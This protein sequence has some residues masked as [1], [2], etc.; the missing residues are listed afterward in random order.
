MHELFEDQAER[1]PHEPAVLF[2]DEMLTYSELNREANRLARTLRT[3]GVGADRPAAIMVHRSA[4]MVIGILAIL[5][6]GGAYVPVDPEYPE[7]RIRYLLEDCGASVLVTERELEA[8]AAFGGTVVLLDEEAAYSGDSANLEP[9]CDDSHLAYI[10]Y[11]SGTTGKPKGVMIEHRQLAAAAAAWNEAYRLREEG[12]RVLQWASFSFDV[13][14]GD[15]VRALLHGGRLILCPAG[16]RMD[17]AGIYELMARHRATFFES[18]PA[19][20]LPF[21][22]YV[23]DRG[24]DLGFLKLLVLGSD[25]CPPEAFATLQQRWGRQMRILNSY[26]VTE[27]CIDSSFYEGTEAEPAARRT[28]PIG[29]PLPGVRMYIVDEHLAL[30]PAGIPGELYIGGHGVGRGYWNRE[31]LTAERFGADPF[32]PEGRMYRTGDLARWLPD[33]NIE[34][35]GRM[36]QQVKIRGFRIETGEVEAAI[37]QFPGVKE[38][39][40][41]AREDG[42]GQKV[43]CAYVVPREG[44]LDLDALKQ[45]LAGKLPAHMVP[46]RWVLL[47]RLPLTPNGKVDRRALPS[48]QESTA[49]V[50]AG[51]VPPRT[52]GERAIASVWQSVL[53]GAAVGMHDSFF[54][55]G[56][57]SI[58]AIQAAS[59]LL[60]EGYRLDLKDLFRYP[61]P[62]EL[63]PHLKAAGR[64]SDQGE[65]SGEVPLTP[66]LHW[67][68]EQEL[69]EPHHYNQAVMLCRRDRFE[70]E[71]LR[72]TAETIAAH[73]DALRLVW[74]KEEGGTQVRNRAVGDGEACRMEVLDLRDLPPIKVAGE[75]SARANAIQRGFRLNEGPLM[76]LCLFQCP[77]GDHLLIVIHHLAVDGVSWRILFEDL[78][79]GYAQASS[80][81]DVRLPLKTASFREWAQAL[82]GEA[83]SGAWETERAYWEA[84]EK[85]DIAPL[86]RDGVCPRPLTGDSGTVTLQLAEADTQRLLKEVHRAYHT[87]ANDILLTALGLAVREWS[88][89]RRIKVNLEGHGREELAAGTD[90]S[91][92]VG[93]FTCQFPVLLELPDGLPLGKQIKHVKET[94][95]RV[96]RKGR[97]YGVLR[98]LSAHGGH[99][100]GAAEPEISFNYLGQFDQDLAGSGF[101]LSPYG[102]GE[103]VSPLAKRPY[104]LDING[105]LKQGR[106]EFEISYCR[107]EYR[108]ETVEGLAALLRSFLE[109]VITHCASRDHSE[110]TPSDVLVQGFSAEELDAF[111]EDV[112]GIGELENLYPLTPMQQ[113]MLFHHLMGDRPEAY[114]EQT[115]VDLKGPLETGALAQSLRL[116]VERHAVL[117]TN[118]LQR[119]DGLPLQAVFR[120]REPELRLVDL[121]MHRGDADR[122]QALLDTSASEDRAR[123][124]N[125]ASD[126][127]MRLTVLRTGEEDYRFLWSFHHVLMDGWCLSLMVEEVFTIYA[128]LAAGKQPELPAAP[129]YSRYIE[130]LGQ[131]E[132]QE[133][134]AYW[135]AYL[136]GYS[137]PTLLPGTLTDGAEEPRAER[138]SCALGRELTGRLSREASKRRTTL[139]SWIQAAWG[140]LLQ[141]YSGSKDVVFGCVVSGRP[142]ELAGADRMLGLF[143]NTVPVRV[144]ADP[145]SPFS[146]VAKRLQEDA[147]AAREHETYPLYE[148]QSRSGQGREL[149]NHIL[150]FENYPAEELLAAPGGLLGSGLKVTGVHAAEQTNYDLNVIVIPGDNLQLHFEYNSRRYP[151]E[152]VERIRGHLL[153]LL[154]QTALRPDGP[155]AELDPLTE[156]E[157]EQILQTF[158]DTS[159]DYPHEASI[160]TLFEEQAA[161]VPDRAAVEF[162]GQ[163]LSYRELNE[164]ADALALLLQ[165]RG[166]KEESPVAILAERSP[167]TVIGLLAILK[168]GGAYVPVDPAFPEERIRYM[169]GDSGA[170]L[171][172]VPDGA[173]S[174][175]PDFG[176]ECLPMDEAAARLDH[177]ERLEPSAGPRSLAYI[178]YTSGTTGQPKGVM[179]EHRSVVRLVRNTDYIDFRP[180]DR[181][182]QTGALGFDA[183]T[184]E[185]WGALLS[186]LS[187]HLVEEHILLDAFLLEET[188]RREGITVMWLTSPLFNQLVQ[189]NPAL[190]TGL[191]TLIVGG[192]ALSPV[193]IRKLKDAHPGLQVVN[194]YGPTE[195]TTFSTTYEIGEH[196]GNSIPIGRPIR[197]SRAYIVDEACRLL[198]I[199]VPGELCVAGDGLSRGYLGRPELTA[200]KFTAD[201]LFPG[202]RMYR[203][204][205]LARWLPDGTIE[206]LGRLDHQVKI[207]GYRIELGEIENRLLLFGGIREA[208]VTAYED[209]AGQKQLCAYV[210]ADRPL[211]ARELKAAL[212]ESLPGYMVPAAFVQLERMPLTRNGK[213]DRRALPEPQAFAP[214]EDRDFAAPETPLEAQLAAIWQ[215]VLGVGRVGRHDDFFELGGHSLRA[216]ALAARIHQ[217]LKRRIPLKELFRFRTVKEQAKQLERLGRAEYS[218]IPRAAER[219]EYP[220]SSAQQRMYLLSLRE[221][222]ELSYNM[223]GALTVSGPLDPER[224]E[225]AFREIVGRHDTLRTSFHTVNG[226]TV[227]RIHAEADFRLEL[228]REESG[229]PDALHPD[230]LEAYMNRFVRPFDLA[231][232]PLMR[233]GCLRRSGESHLLLFDMH[234]IVSDG[235]SMG[236]LVEEFAALYAGRTLPLLATQY[237]DYTMWRQA[238]LESPS[239]KEK[240]AYWLETFQGSLPVLELPADYPRGAVRRFEG[241]TVRFT[242][243]AEE[244]RGLREIAA[245]TGSTLY[246]V[247]LAVYTTL[248]SRYSGAEDL[249]VGTPAAGRHHPDLDP[250]IGMFVD[251]LA[252]RCYPESGIS[253]LAYLQDVR[254][255]SLQAFEHGDYP[256]DLLVE[257]LGAGADSSRH[258]LFDTMFALQNT[259]QRALEADGIRLTPHEPVT[260]AVKFDLTLN[261]VE[262]EEVIDCTLEFACALFKRETAERMA[263]HLLRLVRAVGAAPE[264]KLAELPVLTPEEELLLHG[265][266]ADGADNPLWRITLHEAFEAQVERTPDAAAV[267]FGS[268]RWTYRELNARANRLARTLRQAGLGAGMPAALLTDRSVEMVVGIL[269]ILKAGGA[270]VPID[271]D[272]PEARIR[273]MLEDSGVRMLVLQRAL[274]GR[275]AYDGPRICV[276]DPSFEDGDGTNLAPVSGPDDPA[277]IIYSSGTT[278]RPKG[279][280]TAHRS[281]LRVV[282]ETNYI[283]LDDSDRILQLSNYAFDGSVFDLW[284]ALTS[285]GRLV[286]MAKEDLLDLRLLAETLERERITV[287]FMTTSLFNALVDTDVHALSGTRKVLFGGERASVRHVRKALEHLG[288]GRLIN[289]YGPT[290]TT[291]FATSHEVNRLDESAAGVPIGR[292]LSGTTAYVLSREGALQPVGVP[293]ELCIG[294]AGLAL[295]YLGQEDLTAQKFTPNP[296][297]PAGRLYRTG[298]LVRRLPDGTLE[299]IGRI[300]QQVKI[301]GHRIELGEIEAQLLQLEGIDEAVVLA[302]S[303]EG[304][305]E[306][307]AYYTSGR[308]IAPSEIRQA[309]SGELPGYM[310]PSFFVLLE[311]MPLTRNG[312]IDRDALPAPGEDSRGT[313]VY[314]APQTRTEIRL[315]ELWAEVLGGGR[316][317]RKDS[318]FEVGGHS[319]RAAALA[320]HIYRDLQTNVPLGDLFRHPTLKSMA[321]LIDAGAREEY[322]PIPRAPER[323]YYPVS[324]EQKRIYILS[325]LVGGELSYNMPGV[326]SVEGSLDLRRFEEA[327]RHLIARHEALR[328]GFEMIQGEPV[329]RVHSEVQWAVELLPPLSGKQEAREEI[330]ERIRAFVRP[331]RL[332]EAP[333]LRVGLL[334]TAPGRY[335]MLYDMH[336]I[337]SD[338]ISMGILTREFAALYAGV[339][340]TPL[341][342][343]YK[344][345][346]VWQREGLGR[347]ALEAQEAYWLGVFEGELPLLQL[348]TD[349]PRGGKPDFSAGTVDFV[350]DAS[351]LQ[352]L[353]SLAAASGSTMFML[354][355]SIYHVL[356]AKYSGQ[357][358]L[359]V[360]TPAA[361]RPHPD[362]APLLGMFVGTLALRSRPA[363]SKSFLDFLGEVRESTLQALEHQAY[364]FEELVEKLGI[365]R[366]PGRHPLF[367]TLFALQNMD[368]GD[369]DGTGLQLHPYPSAAPAAKFDLTLNAAEDDRA[370]TCSLEYR[371]ALF[372][373]KTIERMA[374]HYLQ[375]IDAVLEAPESTIAELEMITSAEKQ[376][377]LETFNDTDADIAEGTI[378]GLIEAQAART[379]EA[380]ALLCGKQRFTYRELN[381]RANRLARTLL[382]HDSAQGRIMAVL[383]DRSADAVIAILAV[384]KAGGA[385]VPVDPEYPEERIRY[386]LEDSG[387]DVLL[388]PRGMETGVPF[389]GT[390]IAL[391]EEA[392]YHADGTNLETEVTS[393]DLA[394][395]IYTSGT[396]GRPKGVMVEHRGIL[397]FKLAYDGV[398]GVRAEDKVVQFASMSFDASLSEIT[399]ALFCGAALYLPSAEEVKDYRLLRDYI[400][401]H[402]ITVATLPPAYAA[403][404]AP[405]EVPSLRILITAG[406]AAT[407]ELIRRW[408]GR[409]D[410]FNAYGPT[411]DSICTTIWSA[412]REASDER[413]VRIGRPIANHRVYILSGSGQLQPPGIPGELCIAGTGLARGYL[414]RPELTAEKFADHP[415]EP[416]ARLY[417]TGDLARWLPD[418]TLEHLGRIDHQV[419]I[420]GYRIELGEVES[421]L[422]E[423]PGVRE[424]VV[425]AREDRDGQSELCAYYTADGELTPA[426]VRD[427]LLKLLPGY[428]VPARFHRL[429]RMPLTPNGKI[430]RSRL[431]VPQDGGPSLRTDAAAP[432][433]ALEASLV[434]IWQDVIGVKPVGITDSF[435]E[436]GGHSLKGAHLAARI[437]EELGIGV[438]LRE[439]FEHP[440]VEGLAQVLLRSGRTAAEPIPAAEVRSHYPLSSSQKRLY[441][442]S[443]LEG[444]ELSYNMPGVLLLEGTLDPVRLEEAL[445][446]LIRRHEVLRTSFHLLQGVPM[447]RVWA[448]APFALERLEA[449]FAGTG[450]QDELI[451]VVM[452]GFLR[453]FDLEQ[454]PLLRAGLLGLGEQRHLLLLDM[455]HLVSDGASMRMLTDEFTRLY[456]GE[457]PEPVKLQYKD[458][459]VWQQEGAGRQRAEAQEAY[460]LNC[461][462]GELPVLELPTDRPRTAR[463]SFEGGA[464][465]FRIGPER[466][467][468]LKE[469]AAHSE[470][471]LYMALLALYNT[472]LAKYTGAEDLIVGTPAE[473][474]GHPG[475]AAV[476][477]LFV[478]TLALRTYPAG[479]KPFSAYLKEVRENA[480][481]AFEHQDYGFDSLVEKLDIPRDPSRHPLFDTMFALQQGREGGLS[482]GELTLNSLEAEPAAA[483]F[484][485]SL[486]AEDRGEQIV[487]TFDYAAALFHKETVERFASH[488][489]QLIDSVLEAPYTPIASLRMV[490]ESESMEL[491]KDF[492]HLEPGAAHTAGDT[493]HGLFEA[494]AAR[495]PDAAA[496]VSG[497]V[498]L[499]YRELNQRANGVACALQALG[500]GTGAVVALMAE[501][502]ADLIAGILGI[503][504]S[505]A[506]YVPVGTELPPER[507]RYML[508]DAGAEAVVIQQSLK[509]R[510]PPALHTVLLDGAAA[511]APAAAGPD[512]AGGSRD[513]AYLLYTSGTTG[514][515]KG[516]QIEHRSILNTITWFHDTYEPYLSPS[517][518][519]T[520]E[521]TF[522][523]SLEQIFGTLL[524]GARLHI[525]RKETML[526]GPVFRDYIRRHGIKLLNTTPMLMGELLADVE[527]VEPLQALICGG[528]RLEEGLKDAL[529]AK[530]YELYNHY[531]PTE[532]SV[533]VLVSRCLPGERVTLGRPVRGMAVCILNEHRQLQ[534][535][536]AAGE[537]Y[538]AGAGLARGYLNQPE[539]TA[540]KFTEHPD[541]PGMRLYRTGDRARRLPDGRI[542]FLGRTD[543]QVKIRGYRIEP[544]EIEHAL[545]RIPGVRMTV[546][547]VR[548]DGNGQKQL[549]AYYTAER[550]LPAKEVRVGLSRALPGYMVPAACMQLDRIP[551]TANG[552]V[553][554]RALPEA[555]LSVRSGEPYLA[556]RSETEAKLASLWQEV[557]GLSQPPGVKDHFFELGGHSLRAMTLSARL[558]KTMHR[559]L[560][561]RDMF[562]RPVLEEMADAL[563]R[564]EAGD[565]L[566]LQPAAEREW[567]PVSSAQKR[568]YLLNEFTGESIGYNMPVILI[569]EG[570]LDPDRLQ[571]AFRALIRRQESLRTQ[572][573]MVNGE[574]VQRICAE[575]DYRVQPLFLEAASDSGAVDRMIRVF[576]RPFYLGTAPLIR[577]G[578][579]QMTGSRHLLLFDTHHIVSDGISMSVLIQE[580]AAL[581]A[582]QTLPPLPLQ[583]KDYAVWQQEALTGERMRGQEAYWLD[584][585][586]GE[587][588]VLSL[589][590]DYARGARPS[591][592]GGLVEFKLDAEAGRRLRQLAEDA[593]AT[594]YMV[595]LAA[596]SILL[597]KYGGDE[598][599]VIGTPTAGRPHADLE[600]LIGMF[601]GT[602]ALRVKPERNKS[603]PAYLQEVKET[604]LEAF[605]H[606]DYPFEALVEKLGARRDLSRH[607]LFDTMLVLQNTERRE[608][609]VD[610]LTLKPYPAAHTVSKFDLTLIAAEEEQGLLFQFEYSTALFKRETVERM[611]AHFLQLIGGILEA[612]GSRLGALEILPGEERGLLT[613]AFNDT[614]AGWPSGQTFHALFKEQAR[615]HADR[616]AVVCG[617]GTLTYR[618]LDRLSDGLAAELRGLGV[619]RDMP[620]GLFLGRSA[621]MIVGLLAIL[622][623]GGAF[624]PID[625]GYPGE[626]IAFMLE[627]SGVSLLLT[628]RDILAAYGRAWHGSILLAEGWLTDGIE[629][630]AEKPNIADNV[631]LPVPAE[632]SDA[633]QASPDSAAYLIYTSGTTGRPKGIVVE[634]RGL[635]NLS[636]YWKSDLGIRPEDRIGQFAS[637]SFDASVWEI[638]MALL[639]GAALHIPSDETIRDA[640]AFERYAAAAGLTVLTLPPT[641][642]THLQPERL[643]SL[644]LLVTA[645]SAATPELIARWSRHLTYV[646]A[647]GPTETTIC[648][649]AWTAPGEGASSEST[650]VTI[651]RPLPNTRVYILGPEDRLQPIGA[652]GELCV[653]GVGVARGYLN[654]PELTAEKFTDHPW[655]PGERLY[656]TGDS[657]RWL[658]DGTIEYLGRIDHQVKIRGHRI[659]PGEIE[660]RLL[661]VDGLSEAFVAPYKDLRGSTE[662]CAYYTAVRSIRGPELRQALAASLPSYMIPAAFL[663]LEE[664]PLTPNGKVDR[665]AL[666]EPV[667]TADA[668]AYVPPGDPLEEKLAAIWA[669]VLG[670]ERVGVHDSFF[671]LGGQ[672]MKLLEMVGRVNRELGAELGIGAAFAHATVRELAGHLH[673]R[674]DSQHWTLW[675]VEQGSPVFCFPPVV[676]YGLT[677]AGLA[678]ELRGQ[679]AVLAFDYI[680]EEDRIERYVSVITK[681]Q[682]HGEIRLAG[683]SGGGNLA[684]ETAKEL[685]RLGRTVSMVLLFDS[686]PRLDSLPEAAEE[687]PGDPFEELQSHLA[688]IEP[689]ADL[690]LLES[691]R[692]EITRKMGAYEAYLRSLRQTGRIRADLLL[693]QSENGDEELRSFWNARASEWGGLTAGTLHIVQGRGTHNRML[694]RE[695]CA[696]NL[697]LAQSV[698]LPGTRSAAAI[699]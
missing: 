132:G 211:S 13:F 268:E 150:A 52:A 97:G 438:S 481:G 60:Q 561:L 283:S 328:T 304:G 435:F 592:E 241:D 233:V 240:E 136:D 590:A 168:A 490:T 180:Q 22:D 299:Y 383:A 249:I 448:E 524:Y 474:R 325:Q 254:E 540:E 615:R 323:T 198:P 624:L 429:E 53:G 290:E 392:S 662:L 670:A 434:R 680:E 568:L 194:G 345:Y 518:M 681:H 687:K 51:Y 273:Y 296:F 576:V 582:G 44:E 388:V 436:L 5:K 6:A 103:A 219:Q 300:D 271:P 152:A 16:I 583:Y 121:R 565:Q 443:Q 209:G 32:Q 354:L 693:I 470:S 281:V 409:L 483:K 221:G 638:G 23:Q 262:R 286:L 569:L 73:H 332:E 473:G 520:T 8:R 322:I 666:P 675:N 179:V 113:G 600:Q 692:E 349:E 597:S 278:G 138:V 665:R 575:T 595:L 636:A 125:L 537:L 218:P 334:E 31:E 26:G 486:T 191:R 74:I 426:A 402:G 635:A 320:A 408:R 579:V 657:A 503:L 620:V 2:G 330:G 563:D 376:E 217:E 652:P 510:V 310:I 544:G 477:G 411:E 591:Y 137:G 546:V 459:A 3:H 668:S 119:A 69:A 295:G 618:E 414:G 196:F 469:L 48:P 141:K 366:E 494:Q 398:F 517:V 140:V 174:E 496:V 288:P 541:L 455:H 487:C 282:K 495:T 696:A 594:L 378:H 159:A 202:E 367:D 315:A 525:I 289:V 66:I 335:L 415:F 213:V 450:Q 529:L 201:P 440:T 466:T 437:H 424:A 625:P 509:D 36:D 258:P 570:R 15:L 619:S 573:G 628:R 146:D 57:D 511:C 43:L 404:L 352:G 161:R 216:A 671:D 461:F 464:F 684:F 499:T 551:L 82:Q 11:T 614:E 384:L 577:V 493:L 698:L 71:A 313:A 112:S 56:G 531:G 465:E 449:G 350:I 107:S 505:G 176:I 340:L 462:Q 247:L 183:S 515:P 169:L 88:G 581:Y 611:A 475:L 430:D 142:A 149:V 669:E 661:T 336:H 1:T 385:Y 572:F 118:F 163:S 629:A 54:E 646:N 111:A 639:T 485:L 351:R 578:L 17:P 165:A 117:R 672:S 277:Y 463:R 19:L 512:P 139:S 390:R 617:G 344:D 93:W 369:T 199:G 270:Y 637:I 686:Y 46:A 309:L 358:D 423:Q 603:F 123:G 244:S 124:F 488:Y 616:P 144:A 416:G 250:L 604:A 596:Y 75:V 444:G 40:A 173:G 562:L 95:R 154:E 695:H 484:D 536:G 256:F 368:R 164:R 547:I 688:S 30:Q 492:H 630:A 361:G 685:E 394:Y 374:A 498:R 207:R 522:D 601:V 106:L 651:G 229:S 98:Y 346:A 162:G 528:E 245:R 674:T 397:N 489:L 523:P 543:D 553:D 99:L 87:E 643:P 195:N 506:A 479:D 678:H 317:G 316:Y 606:Q 135:T 382:A 691:G 338:G 255:R 586:R 257:K 128:A 433:T 28:L 90:V 27:A 248:L 251:T 92:T 428:M 287:L 530:G 21:M 580:F 406:S 441:L 89:L 81:Q 214:E 279:I 62:A 158:N 642:V 70:P 29:R 359:I 102:I 539:L 609:N 555:D 130:W 566:P 682:P 20:I 380:A 86:P 185:I 267:R 599:M 110:L 4:R 166:V 205:D 482:L 85:A 272:Y 41:A 527:R 153:A 598:D 476:Q 480:L 396:T 456:A 105:M 246:M 679:A 65:V 452:Q 239:M 497:E 585:F 694:D 231:T 419:K 508:E 104:V 101:A 663:Q 318:F 439:I 203:T 593:G 175:R 134:A 145:G 269:A 648:A 631:D 284:A 607:P 645:G 291:V 252:L 550:E 83:E 534:P 626:R 227:Q 364:P 265:F 222:G 391:G 59:K 389:S 206:Y 129:P 10:I 622:K 147:A 556:P 365:A 552:K 186:G 564:L 588:P 47:G 91:R 188:V 422:A 467:R 114:F 108:R 567:Y 633:S 204:G 292:P 373:E 513:L 238:E 659:E 584:V 401:R 516:V 321:G 447:Q 602:L 324:S 650:P 228:L 170:R 654:R 182:L 230:E 200:E 68:G 427:G 312:K 502:S 148:I 387:A 421:R 116:L 442:L 58:K 64:A 327:F 589:P 420:R 587:L 301:R 171:L 347:T 549:C 115:A 193:H 331:F 532:A 126:A 386:M 355:K 314:E 94:L 432:R 356:L 412:S 360:G 306:L 223:P 451:R 560:P 605:E 302:G 157:K 647:Y 519:L 664:L 613:E 559:T 471:T 535:V 445:R 658:A 653:A 478:N 224:L 275:T 210:T 187:L 39:V 533:D 33:G 417:R 319:L 690:S 574:P 232:P 418:G 372:G 276:D 348:P 425:L 379:P 399:M 243:G 63:A 264:T 395:V 84:A 656:R 342:N 172:L 308:A 413:R 558:Y 177:R 72:R 403:Y 55:L 226:E 542:E 127:L 38:A 37:L 35:L 362:L 660:A 339:Q 353:R 156:E 253:F 504:K 303:G 375:L 460:W 242:I 341:K 297:D 42:N 305:L 184:F 453:P 491:L 407:S 381:E 500:I 697:A 294:G 472:L 45:A 151:R 514:T 683:Y 266:N 274:A 521:Y 285:G 329:Q 307:A 410:Y 237:K 79:A 311:R 363:G 632:A 178:L 333:L 557:L 80:G 234:H 644:R 50:T 76:R 61:T 454:A 109:E 377:L 167:E 208:V 120:T 25:I 192:D 18:T 545:S 131:Q 538:L 77:D 371:S 181:I 298:D 259:G 457:D 189:Q 640:G 160:C 649:T 689:S 431:P 627:D 7:E 571:E 405:E 370:I 155:A 458:Y 197:N 623:A 676:G 554:R 393:R 610:G 67:F 49:T 24:L 667:H 673:S 215:E 400:G 655:V 212:S 34:Y 133:S 78:A 326:L 337:I 501:P 608:I 261:A 143:I 100:E 225:A 96:P 235:A 699:R 343:Q 612:P 526:N 641:Y 293:G 260:P 236:I 12:V 677:F 634:H 220:V 507:I 621:E 263:G 190:F 548:E 280:L 446:G 14:T 357:E 122:L 468:R 9:V